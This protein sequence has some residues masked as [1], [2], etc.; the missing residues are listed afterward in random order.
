[1]SN[2]NLE[3]LLEEMENITIKRN[4][5]TIRVILPYRKEM[6]N[7]LE[8]LYKYFGKIFANY[9]REGIISLSVLSKPSKQVLLQTTYGETLNIQKVGN[10]LQVIYQPSITNFLD[11]FLYVFLR[12][13]SYIKGQPRNQQIFF[14]PNYDKADFDEFINLFKRIKQQI[15]KKGYKV[16]VS[17]SDPTQGN[18]S[19]IFFGNKK[20]RKEIPFIYI[21]GKGSTL[22]IKYDGEACWGYSINS[23]YKGLINILYNYKMRGD[24]DV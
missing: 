4:E 5:T 18:L 10:K 24:K 3:L 16:I 1:M 13:T 22:L 2:Y 14:I 17:D 9:K 23:P 6:F 15:E 21:K 11:S 7:N 20:R 12:S 19:F 8:G